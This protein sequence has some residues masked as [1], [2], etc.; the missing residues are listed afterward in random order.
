MSKI[1]RHH[2]IPRSYRRF[3][4]VLNLFPLCEFGMDGKVGCHKLFDTADWK[5]HTARIMKKLPNT[6]VD[7]LRENSREWSFWL[8]WDDEKG[9]HG[10][11]T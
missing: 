1:S 4:H 2:I 7:F 9:S 10:E 8:Y 3:D 5:Y 6:T 11:N